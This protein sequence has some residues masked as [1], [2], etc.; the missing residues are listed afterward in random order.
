M[1]KRIQQR[2]TKGWR[3]P[4]FTKS[5]ARPSR[6]GNPYRIAEYKIDYPEADAAE[7]Q[8]MAVSDF[9]GL[10]TA[11][12][13]AERYGVKPSVITCIKQGKTWGWVE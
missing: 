12:R 9:R 5:V 11:A 1:P 10:V 7:L 2:R 3:M 4:L 6:W 8:R 13:L